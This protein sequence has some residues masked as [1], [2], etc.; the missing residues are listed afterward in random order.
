MADIDLGAY[1]ARIGQADMALPPT[2]G[3][4]STL[5]GAHMRSIPFENLDV[6]LG[7]PIRLDAASVQDKL[8]AAGRGGYCFEH[9]SLFAAVL[10]ALG[11]DLTRHTARVVLILSRTQA[12]RAHM[13]LTVR[14]PEGVFIADPGLG[15]PASTRPL[16]LVDAGAEGPA[17]ASHWMTRDGPYWTLRTRGPGGPMD[18]WVSTVEPD[19]LVD[20]EVGNH[21]VATHPGSPFRQRL[22][23]GRFTPEGRVAVMNREASIRR[24]DATETV[25]LPDR[26]ALRRFAAEHLA[27][28]LPAL[29]TLRV[30]AVPD[31]S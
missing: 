6:L 21:F 9:A 5:L 11:F 18:V 19:N 12:P 24:G 23:L 1:G 3:T 16:P 20:F 15:G 29:E 14:L 25:Q 13:F 10:E 2:L 4:L 22:M 7:H 17:G 26:A 30:P 28:D 8:V 27:L 31:W